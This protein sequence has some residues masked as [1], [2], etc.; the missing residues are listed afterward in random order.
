MSTNKKP[1]RKKITKKKVTHKPNNESDPVIQREETVLI[2]NARLTHVIEQ[3]HLLLD[4]H[5]DL[6]VQTLNTDPLLLA[7]IEQRKAAEGVCLLIGLEKDM[8][9]W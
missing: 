3:L 7:V 4:K 6:E 1:A 8:G 5:G 9:C 2:S